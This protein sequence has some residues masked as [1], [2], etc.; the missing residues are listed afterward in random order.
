MVFDTSRTI[1]LI[2]LTISTGTI[3]LLVYSYFALLLDIKELFYF[4]AILQKFGRWRE[5]IK[6]TDEVLLDSSIENDEL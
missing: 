4:K 1:D 6:G 2:A 3:A 5:P